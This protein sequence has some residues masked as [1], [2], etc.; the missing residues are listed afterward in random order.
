ML[1]DDESES[2]EHNQKLYETH[3][4]SVF[5]PFDSR[6]LFIYNNYAAYGPIQIDMGNNIQ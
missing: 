3:S 4:H 1:Y 6:I 5:S 2:M